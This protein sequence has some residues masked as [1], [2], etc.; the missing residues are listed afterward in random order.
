LDVCLQT[1]YNFLPYTPNQNK[2][3][4]TPYLAVGFA[5]ALVAGSDAGTSNFISL[6]FS[7]GL[8]FTVSS[9]IS[10]GLEWS[11]RKTF[12]DRL[13]GLENP[14]GKSSVLHNNDWYSML[15]VFIT[16]KFFKFATDCPAYK[17]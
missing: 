4:Y 12:T 16:F 2:W 3:D 15:G 1:E 7:A 13:D 14:S 6:P 11:F 17:E 8:K 9:R 5:G 10:A